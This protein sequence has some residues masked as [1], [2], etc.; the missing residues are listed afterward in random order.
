M[1]TMSV[2]PL[3]IARTDGVYLQHK[4]LAHD[5]ARNCLG[6]FSRTLTRGRF[7]LR[8]VDDVCNDHG[9]W[10]ISRANRIIR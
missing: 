4:C 8:Y 1:L 6:V 9:I 5:S 10:K 2:M 7:Q 3:K